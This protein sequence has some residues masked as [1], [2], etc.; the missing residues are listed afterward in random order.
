MKTSRDFVSVVFDAIFKNVRCIRYMAALAIA[1]TYEFVSVYFSTMRRKRTINKIKRLHSDNILFI[2]EQRVGY[3]FA[4]ISRKYFESVAQICIHRNA[5][6][7]MSTSA[8]V[9]M[10][11]IGLYI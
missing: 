3:I 9:S 7:L 1:L 10:L 2:R 11:S 5:I 4:C 8:F 6:V